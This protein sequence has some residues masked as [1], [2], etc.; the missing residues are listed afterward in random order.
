LKS[1]V[2]ACGAEKGLYKTQE[3][4]EVVISTIKTYIRDLIA[5]DMLDDI[6]SKTVQAN[7]DIADKLE[8]AKHD[9]ESW[10]KA[11]ENSNTELMKIFM[12]EASP[13]NKEQLTELYE[14]AVKELDRATKV[15]AEVAEIMNSESANEVDVLKL[16]DLL[17]NWEVFFENATVEIKRQ[18]IR[19]LVSEV[20]LKGKEITVEIAFDV[21]KYIENISLVT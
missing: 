18:M 1:G 13:F 6:K 10:I 9:M 11:K 7:K 15:Y 2:A 5:T 4:E 21:A 20:S 8:V 19:A 17:N 3:I 14:K 12:G 16:Q